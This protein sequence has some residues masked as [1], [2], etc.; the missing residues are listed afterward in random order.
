M[1]QSPNTAEYRRVRD[2]IPYLVLIGG[3]IFTS[4]VSYRL[5]QGTEAEDRARFQGLVQQVHV[6]I[7]SRLETYSALV[8]SGAGLFAASESVDDK[9]FK[10][11][12]DR[13]KVAENYPGIRGIGFTVRVKPEERLALIDMMS[14]QGN[15]E[16]RVWPESPRSEYHSVIYAQPPN[17]RNRALIGFDMSTEPIRR[18]AMERARDTGQPAASHR[19]PPVTQINNENVQGG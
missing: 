17:E 12:V 13:L 4:I 18:A 14:R 9:E 8:L 16:F 1:A 19:V 2:L 3:L 6:G 10:S 11:F 5:A 15:A 7:E